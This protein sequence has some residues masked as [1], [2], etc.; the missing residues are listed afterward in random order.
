MMPTSSIMILCITFILCFFSL[1]A[2]DGDTLV[3]GQSLSSNSTLVSSSG[4]FELGFFTPGFSLREYVGVWY[5]FDKAAVIWV[6]NREL[7]VVKA[8]GKLTLRKNGVLEI[9]DREN[10]VVWSS[11]SND[12][13]LTPVAQLLDSGN[14]VVRNGNR[15]ALDAFT[16]Q[17]FDYPCNTRVPRMKIG[18]D[19]RNKRNVYQSSW[20]SLDDPAEGEFIFKLDITGVPQY[21]F[22]NGSQE[23]FRTGPW[24]GQSF[25]GTPHLRPDSFYRFSYISDDEWIYFL[26]EP[27]SSSVLSRTVVDVNGTWHRFIWN[28]KNRD[29]NMTFAFVNDICDTYNRC[30][31]YATCNRNKS[32]ICECLKGYVPH[33]TKD[34]DI[35][36]WTKGCVI[37]FSANCSRGDKF[38]K[39]SNVKVPD[40]RNAY[41]SMSLSLEECRMACLENCSCTAY[42]S[43]YVTY[44]GTGCLRW[45]GELNDIRVYAENG[46]DIFVRSNYSDTDSFLDRRGS[47]AK[48]LKVVMISSMLSALVLVSVVIFIICHQR[49]KTHLPRQSGTKDEMS[50]NDDDLDLPLFDMET[51]SRATNSFSVENKLGEGGFGPVYKGLLQGGQEIAVK[52]LS[53]DS[54]Q[55]S[56][57]FKNEV[58]CIAKLQHRNL[59]KL[60]GCCNQEEYMLIYEFM[61]NKSLDLFIF[62]DKER[63]HLDWPKRLNII[64]GIARGLLYLHQD[65]RLRIIHR[66]LKASNVLLD[67]DMNPKISDFGLARICGGSE[68]S[69]NTT[70]V[71]GTYG[72]MSPEY[73]LEGIF[74]VKS[75]I[76]S[77]GVLV[78]EIISGKRN[79]GFNHPDHHLNLLGHTWKLFNDGRFTEA[80]D[81]S[82]TESYDTSEVTRAIHVGLL[83][84]QENSHNRPDMGNVVSMLSSDSRLPP[85]KVPGFFTSM[86]SVKPDSSSSNVDLCSVNE[87]SIT[88]MSPR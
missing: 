40:T 83:C 28:N 34:W 7:P 29:W 37:G 52:K 24:N 48:G 9:S 26:H 19:V 44:E 64:N 11:S 45:Y 88:L 70:K 33:S 5:K 32:P 72:Y 53:Q 6:A 79:R 25:S 74:S 54:K 1:E 14:F 71:V 73:A 2:V 30:G 59:V 43:W 13:V 4:I 47:N 86:K 69:A 21:F 10:V 12:S 55:G 3:V 75:D 8:P 39:L 58:M 56:V 46:Q 61:P 65:S 22:K 63:I 80:V 62:D 66:D 85:A 82:L 38:Y 17:G 50:T 16:W 60:L 57:E 78:L 81:E 68:T 15:T 36:D 87:M 20:K 67:S 49:R 27:I 77:F 42:G 23:T 41:G 51:L 84:V 35:A 31:P 76:F 18:Y